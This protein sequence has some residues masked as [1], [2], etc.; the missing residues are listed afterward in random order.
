MGLA[1]LVNLLQRLSSDCQRIYDRQP[2]FSNESRERY[3]LRKEMLRTDGISLIFVGRTGRASEITIGM[4]Q[5]PS[6]PSL[7]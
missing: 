2:N 5:R 6:S 1:L 3:R 7:P 4:S